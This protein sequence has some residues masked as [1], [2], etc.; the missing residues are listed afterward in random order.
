[1]YIIQELKAIDEYKHL[2]LSSLQG[3]CVKHVPCIESGQSELY[4]K[5]W[6]ESYKAITQHLPHKQNTE[7]MHC[8]QAFSALLVIVALAASQFECSH[9]KHHGSVRG[10]PVADIAKQVGE[11]A[12]TKLPELLSGSRNAQLGQGKQR[13]FEWFE[14]EMESLVHTI[15]FLW[16]SGMHASRMMRQQ[17]SNDSDFSSSGSNPL[18]KLTEILRSKHAEPLHSGNIDLE[19][20]KKLWTLN[21][22]ILKDKRHA[23]PVQSQFEGMSAADRTMDRASRLN[24]LRMDSRAPLMTGL[25]TGADGLMHHEHH[26]KRHFAKLGGGG[27]LGAKKINQLESQL[28]ATQLQLQRLEQVLGVRV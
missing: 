19:N 18:S 2:W 6:L 22:F 13:F 23:M 11:E 26:G 4:K 27:A 15:F 17:R 8:F 16:A 7:K 25:R 14:D 9:L 1:M 20:S 24:A 5:D 12:V 10:S 28:L 3:E 21:Q